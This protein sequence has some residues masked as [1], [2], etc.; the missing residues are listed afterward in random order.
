MRPPIPL[1]AALSLLACDPS[2]VAM[3][4]ADEVSCLSKMCPL[5]TACMATDHGPVCA[6]SCE[7]DDDCGE[8]W[9]C[10]ESTSGD[11]CAQSADCAL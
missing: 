7:T 9:V 10:C 11:R 8:G 1:L 3:A 2:D 4:V 6:P 5:D